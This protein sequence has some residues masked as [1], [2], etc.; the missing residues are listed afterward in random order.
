MEM[1][2]FFPQLIQ[3]GWDSTSNEKMGYDRSV[4]L[5]WWETVWNSFESHGEVK[6]KD[7]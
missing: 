1:V 7:T 5:I 4:K 6:R 2:R 3:C